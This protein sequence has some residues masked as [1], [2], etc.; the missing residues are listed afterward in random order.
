MGWGA[1][2]LPKVHGFPVLNPWV[3]QGIS[4]GC[5]WYSWVFEGC[6]LSG[7]MILEFVKVI[8]THVYITWSTSFCSKCSKCLS[9]ATRLHACDKK[10]LSWSIAK[11]LWCRM[12]RAEHWKPTGL[13]PN[14]GYEGV[15]FL[16]CLSIVHF[17][18]FFAFSVFSCCLLFWFP[19]LAASP[20]PALLFLA[21]SQTLHPQK[22]MQNASQH[23]NINCT[24]SS[25]HK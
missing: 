25:L 14:E 6:G 3:Y 21:T 10:V 11:H 13:H 16:V 24:A 1:A 9:K 23:S 5:Q 20:I 15:H 19:G 18:M 7:A 2:G 4:G 8:M 12:C 22:R 17:I